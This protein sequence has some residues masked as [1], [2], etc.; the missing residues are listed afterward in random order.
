MQVKAIYEDGVINFTQ[1]LR[2]KHSRFEVIVNIPEVELDDLPVSPSI[3][4][5]GGVKG[6]N[7]HSAAELLLIKI[8]QILGSYYRQ[9][10]SSSV[11]Q[12]KA[13]YLEA[14]EEKYNR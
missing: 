3:S 10:P 6:D 4:A 14:L 12:D 1:P 7:N 13:T 8:K 5:S 11:E 9:H 2:F